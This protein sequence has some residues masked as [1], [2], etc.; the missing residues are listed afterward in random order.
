MKLP[1]KFRAKKASVKPKEEE[2]LNEILALKAENEQLRNALSELEAKKKQR[3][4]K[5]EQ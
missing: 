4:K 2:L 5:E 3:K 1:V